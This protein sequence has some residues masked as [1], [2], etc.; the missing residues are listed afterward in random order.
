M[1]AVIYGAVKLHFISI[2]SHSLRVQ[3][4]E[5]E[6]SS[7][8]QLCC[9]QSSSLMNLQIR[10]TCW[11]M[12]NRWLIHHSMKLIWIK[13]T[14]TLDLQDY[15]IAVNWSR[16]HMFT[17]WMHFM[18]NYFFV[19]KRHHSVWLH[20]VCRNVAHSKSSMTIAL[21][22]IAVS[23]AHMDTTQALMSNSRSVDS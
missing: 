23:C 17:F 2:D 12:T 18:W 20:I 11:C 4:W 9:I 10:I 7:S 6:N 14:Q 19:S 21:D 3:M 1:Q 22:R 16:L 8:C 13:S 15:S 5:T